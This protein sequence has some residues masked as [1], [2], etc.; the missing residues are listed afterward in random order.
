MSIIF[1]SHEKCY[2][3][4]KKIPKLSNLLLLSILRSALHMIFTWFISKMHSFVLK[5]LS[6]LNRHYFWTRLNRLCWNLGNSSLNSQRLYRVGSL[7][8]WFNQAGIESLFSR[9]RKS[10][11]LLYKHRQ[12][13]SQWVLVFLSWLQGV[14][15]PKR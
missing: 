11:G 3:Y 1:N 12:H 7:R 2:F 9:P 13:T 14:S 6:H 5:L 10:Q 15:K 4:T 8:S